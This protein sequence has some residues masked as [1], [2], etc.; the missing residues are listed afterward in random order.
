MAVTGRNRR[1]YL[2]TKG[3]MATYTWLAGEQS[4]NFSIESEMLETTD[5]SSDFRQYIPGIKG[6]SADVTVFADTAASGP[7]HQL[8]SA[9]YKGESVYVFI[10]TLGDDGQPAEGDAFEAYIASISTPNEISGVV[11]RSIT[12]QITGEITHLPEVN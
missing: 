11:T 5:K 4:N 12:L 2:T 6:G 9:L 10:G 1:V 3:G 7:Q 8:I